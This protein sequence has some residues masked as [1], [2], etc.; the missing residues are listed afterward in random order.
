MAYSVFTESLSTVKLSRS[1]SL[2]ATLCNRHAGGFRTT[3]K[4]AKTNSVLS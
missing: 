2:T 3:D 1:H 4:R